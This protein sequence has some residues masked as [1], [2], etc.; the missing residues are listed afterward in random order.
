MFQLRFSLKFYLGIIF[1]IISLVVG[2][3]SKILFFLYFNEVSLRLVWAVIYLVSWP[4]LF[5]GVWWAGSETY[6]NIRKY[7]SYRFYKE[8]LHEG[9]QKVRER[10][11]E[12]KER[13]KN[14][15][16]RKTA[17]RII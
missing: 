7:F 1:I 13:V 4:V 10:T 12:I 17:H 15:I 8:H 16:Q 5:W 9:T 11:R 14:R 6:E 3:L 2:N